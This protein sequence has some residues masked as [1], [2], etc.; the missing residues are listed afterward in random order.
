[1][2]TMRGFKQKKLQKN[3]IL[4]HYF[5]ADQLFNIDMFDTS[6]DKILGFM[7]RGEPVLESYQKL[8]ESNLSVREVYERGSEHMTNLGIYGV[9]GSFFMDSYWET[10]LLF[11]HSDGF[12]YSDTM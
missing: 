4:P 5:L 10:L 8:E 9:E 3:R 2:Y 6:V 7:K 1:M 12:V 11:D